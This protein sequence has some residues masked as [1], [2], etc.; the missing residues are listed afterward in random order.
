MRALWTAA[1]GMKAQQ[2][3]V[4]V[5][6]HNIAN[7]NTTGFKGQ[8]IE[9]KDLLYTYSNPV[10]NNVEMGQP[11]NIQVGHGVMPVATSRK[12]TVGNADRTES[13]TDL[14]IVQGNSSFF[15]IENPNAVGSE[16]NRFYTRDGNFKFSVEDNQLTLVTSQG[17]KVLTT[18]G[19]YIQLP[20]NSKEFS[21]SQNGT[22]TAKTPENEL[23]E[24]G[25][26]MTFKFLNPE[27]LK[28]IGDNFYV[29]T[30][31][32]GEPITEENGTRESKIYQ[33]YLEMSNVQLVD[34]MV[35]MITAQR[36]YEI[37]SKSVQTADDMLNTINQLKR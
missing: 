9:F 37:N 12:F 25:Q 2:L 19:G 24:L 36:A 26:I 10:S 7:V 13:P 29:T 16:T 18:D 31:N 8:K 20:E 17:E 11:V 34:E 35:R 32:S 1:T 30:E 15:V 33:G 23:L 5:I 3:N 6:S 21:V 4:D 14:A 22:V 27:G 28:S